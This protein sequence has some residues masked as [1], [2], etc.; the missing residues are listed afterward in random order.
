MFFL[1]HI[2]IATPILSQEEG[3]ATVS[4]IS[5]SLQTVTPEKMTIEDEESF[6]AVAIQMYAGKF[7]SLW[8]L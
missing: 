6:M 4:F 8:L 5:E 3:T 2:T 7:S 1:W